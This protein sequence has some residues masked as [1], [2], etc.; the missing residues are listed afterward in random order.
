MQH[1]YNPQNDIDTGQSIKCTAFAR[2]TWPK[3]SGVSGFSYMV[4][5]YPVKAVKTGNWC[6]TVCQGVKTLSTDILVVDWFVGLLF[7]VG[8]CRCPILLP[9]FNDRAVV[10]LLRRMKI[11][12]TRDRSMCNAKMSVDEV[13]DLVADC[14]IYVGLSVGWLISADC[15]HL[16]FV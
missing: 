16:F 12:G 10:F 13:L 7:I 8:L 5:R 6:L 11:R 14:F 9:S 1:A 2:K 15:F 4:R 3:K